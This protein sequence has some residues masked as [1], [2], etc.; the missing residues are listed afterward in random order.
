MSLVVLTIP[1]CA[2][3]VQNP[4]ETTSK[5]VFA[6]LP[7]HRQVQFLDSV[8]SKYYEMPVSIPLADLKWYCAEAIR[9][10]TA[11][12]NAH[13]EIIGWRRLSQ[14]FS[15]TLNE[16]DSALTV[17]L[18]AIEYA[19][20]ARDTALLASTLITTSLVYLDNFNNY[21][22]AE[23]YALECIRLAEPLRLMPL[24]GFAFNIIGDVH[25]RLGN[26]REALL[27]CRRSLQVRETCGDD[28]TN[29][30]WSLH[31]VGLAEQALGNLDTAIVCHKRSLELWTRVHDNYGLPQAWKNLGVAY[32]LKGNHAE[33]IVYLRTSVK[34]RRAFS[35]QGHYLPPI[36]TLLAAEERSIGNLAAS[37]ET[38]QQAFHTASLG[39]MQQVMA[40]A[41]R[42]LALTYKTLGR[43]NQA[44]YWQERS[45]VLQDSAVRATM[46]RAISEMSTR[47][48]IEEEG[49]RQTTRLRLSEQKE[50][51]AGL[52]LQQE[53]QTR[54][55]IFMG[56]AASVIAAGLFF[57]R[58]RFT[59]ILQHRAEQEAQRARISRNMHDE[60]GAGLTSISLLSEL[61]RLSSSP[62]TT[63]A[64]VVKIQTTTVGIG[65][66]MR[67]IIWSLNPKNDIPTVF[68]PYLRAFAG[69]FLSNADINFYADF[70]DFNDSELHTKLYTNTPTGVL[71]RIVSILPVFPRQLLTKPFPEDVSEQEHHFKLTGEARRAIFLVVKEALNNTVKYASAREVRFTVR[72][73]S[74]CYEFVIADNGC[75]FVPENVPPHARMNGLENMRKRIEELQGTYRLDSA[76]GQ[77]T[78]VRLVVP[79]SA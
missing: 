41:C 36:L 4:V 63:T 43:F 20:V 39:K 38:G 79:L 60:V 15:F 16:G 61:A 74:D 27:F 70:P 62:E 18:R 32:S 34:L 12:N 66:A 54:A 73:Q 3:T 72:L 24:V 8:L 2:Q 47:F 7:V 50:Q 33:A 21:H 35:P 25:L 6:A 56:L 44:F 1:M 67:E 57:Q 5:S 45:S 64:H 51:I 13:L 68:L 53:Q 14:I 59:Q 46:Q 22:K 31:N 17:S 30:A 48:H 9:M 69:D 37:L 26:P 49:I 10:G 58:Y 19:R 28:L 78:T 29:I 76:P 23:E 40:D 71:G 77:G 42:E 75:G 52:R 11:T 55:L 65:N